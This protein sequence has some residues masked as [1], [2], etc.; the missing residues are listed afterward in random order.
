MDKHPSSA[1]AWQ[2]QLLP[3]VAQRAAHCRHRF[4]C[5]YQICYNLPDPPQ[6]PTP[7]RPLS[8][9]TESPPLGPPPP[10]PCGAPQPGLAPGPAGGR[11]PGQKDG[12]TVETYI[13]PV[14]NSGAPGAADR[15]TGWP[16]CR[17][18]RPAV[19]TI[20][21]S[22]ARLGGGGAGSLL[23][24]HINR[25]HPPF[26]ASPR[27]PFA[28]P[29]SSA[30]SVQLPH[31]LGQVGLVYRLI[32]LP[33]QSAIL[34]AQLAQLSFLPGQCLAGAENKGGR[35]GDLRERACSVAC[36]RGSSGGTCDSGPLCKPTPAVNMRSADPAV[37]PCLQTI[38]Q[39]G[40]QRAQ[41]S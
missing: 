4:G 23:P 1:H 11:E 18:A 15:A 14:L 37:L 39:R 27:P 29:A 36:G 20:C 22:C 16:A 17:D 7:A 3:H 9:G 30:D 2:A 26:P 12:S 28:Q 38:I 34:A 5:V 41:Q 10:P 40:M 21:K 33:G 25:S 13:H 35:H 24:C 32:V 19:D 8:P 6:L 31:L